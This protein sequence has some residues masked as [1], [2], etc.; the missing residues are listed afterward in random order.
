MA[1]TVEQLVERRQWIGGSDAA[2]ILGLSPWATPMDIY[3]DKRGEVEPDVNPSEAAEIGDRMEPMLVEWARDRIDPDAALERD[4]R[5][6]DGIFTAQLDGWLPEHGVPIE[7]KTAGLKSPMFRPDDSGWGDDGTDQIPVHYLCQVNLQLMVS[8]AER[9]VV[10]AFLG[11]GVGPRMYEIPRHERLIREIRSRCERFWHEH[12]LKG[13]PPEGMPTLDVSKRRLRE[14]EKITTIPE[15][16]GQQLARIKEQK[17]LIADAEK[18]AMQDVLGHLG[19][20]E[21][22]DWGWGQVTYRADKRGR[23]SLRV[24]E[25]N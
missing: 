4:Q 19:D 17:K 23:R 5:F 3:L 18:L 15:E 9:A 7:A 10:M 16:V 25:R 24:K 22:G 12:V 20:A 11:G 6:S 14:P 21:V 13:V 2:A 1:L 8:G